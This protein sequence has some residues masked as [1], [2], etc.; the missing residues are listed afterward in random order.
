[1]D[2]QCNRRPWFRKF[3]T[4]LSACETLDDFDTILRTK[5]SKWRGK[6]TV[7][8]GGT[9]ALGEEVDDEDSWVLM[10]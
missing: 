10:P 5:V 2:F 4:A 8:L 3:R 9:E 1:M 6:S 7:Y